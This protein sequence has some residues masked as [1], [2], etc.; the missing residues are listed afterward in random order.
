MQW[1]RLGP[2]RVVV[3]SADRAWLHTCRSADVFDPFS[4]PM[5]GPGTPATTARLLDGA[6]GAGRA[7][8]AIT[9]TAPLLPLTANRWIWRLVGYYHLT[10]HT[11]GL[12]RGA[13]DA[14][15]QAGRQDLA[16]WAREKAD[17]EDHHD[18]LA[19]KDLED[20]GIDGA[21]LVAAELPETAGALVRYFHDSVAE[22]VP[23]R[24]LGYAH[25][26]ERLAI[27]QGQGSIDRVRAVLPPG[28]RAWRSLKVHSGVGSDVKHVAENVDIIATL[29]P[30][31]RSR[32]AVACHDVAALLFRTPNAGQL[33]EA[34]LVERLVPWHR[35]GRDHVQRE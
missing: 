16:D 5:T 25:A 27:A 10:T 18:R 22:S 12:M 7:T 29:A 30:A 15:S 28:S 6:L 11:P 19:L 35:A 33:S 4:Q 24:C 20:L 9:W 21:G 13:A 23:L 17:D 26:V 8:A 32:V 31:E 34:D 1:V 2:E 14:F 3:A